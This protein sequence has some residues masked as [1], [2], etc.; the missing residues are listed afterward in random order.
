[1]GCVD[2][3]DVIFAAAAADDDDALTPVDFRLVFLSLPLANLR[4]FSE[5][6]SETSPSS[7][8]RRYF[9]TNASDDDDDLGGGLEESSENRLLTLTNPGMTV[10]AV[11]V[12]VAA[13]ELGVG[14][15]AGAI[16]LAV[17]ETLFLT[18]LAVFAG[19]SLSLL[20]GTGSL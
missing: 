16:I 7:K 4:S 11:V 15:A 3:V 17:D 6:V 12:E 9:F 18:P 1:M 8:S 2:V 10:V 5:S 14:M 19:N 13:E 20:E